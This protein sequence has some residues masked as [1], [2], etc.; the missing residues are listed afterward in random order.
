MNT[1]LA[2]TIHDTEPAAPRRRRTQAERVAESD[3]RMLDAATA[4]IARMGYAGT[5]LESIGSEAGY[6]RQLVA[7]RF[8]SKDKLLEAVISGHGD[9]LRVRAQDR[10]RSLAGLQAL[11]TEVDS[12]LQALDSPSV[13]SRAFFVLMMES[14]GPA[15]QFRP[16]FAAI[17][18]RWEDSLAETIRDAQA[19]GAI[20]KDVDAHMEAMLLIATLRGGAHPVIDGPRAKQR[21]GRHQRDQAVVGRA[22]DGTQRRVAPFATRRTLGVASPARY[23]RGVPC[24]H[25]G[26]LWN[27]PIHPCCHRSTWP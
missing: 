24:T 12:Y 13:Q 21:A 10:R 16:V 23:D 3:R 2:A 26:P 8:G 5:T 4:L 18:A 9:T 6:S 14:A 11:F 25:A 15:P 1:K 27:T 19:L 20:R 7:Q 17:T 22:A